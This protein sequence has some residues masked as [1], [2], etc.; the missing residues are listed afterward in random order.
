MPDELRAQSEYDPRELSETELDDVTA[1]DGGGLGYDLQDP[2][3]RDQQKGPGDGP[4]GQTPT[5]YIA[6]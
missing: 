6:F 4:P 3:V 1:G 2:A 5:Y